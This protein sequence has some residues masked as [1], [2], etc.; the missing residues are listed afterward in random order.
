MRR[1]FESM[2]EFVRRAFPHGFQ[3]SG[4]NHAVPRV[5][6]EAI[7]VGS[8]LARR[9]H[10]QLEVRPEEIDRRMREAGFDKVVV[11]DGANVRAKL[12]GRIDLVKNIVIGR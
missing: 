3:K 2:L 7:S 8:T 1:E 5:R 9:E 11:S 12:E 10:P 6:F 4:A